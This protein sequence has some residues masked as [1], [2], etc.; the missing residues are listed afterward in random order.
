M[1]ERGLEALDPQV[2]SLTAVLRKPVQVWYLEMASPEELR[3]AAPVEA[4]IEVVED[5]AVNRRFYEQVGRAHHWVDNLGR[6][7]DWWAEH[8]AGKTTLVASMDGEPAGYATL[9]PLLDGSVD[10]AYFGILPRFQ[11]RGLG[12]HLL[13]EAVRM[14][15]DMGAERVTLNTCAL[16]GQGALPNYKRRGFTVVREA[17]EERGIS[18]LAAS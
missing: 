18:D 11:G 17:I 15:W 9:N 5:P 2:T 4:Q 16:D 3:P 6:D 8:A 12:G 10:V 13:T 14:A 7:D 1:T